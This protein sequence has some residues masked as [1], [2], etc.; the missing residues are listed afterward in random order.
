MSEPDFWKAT[1]TAK[2]CDAAQAALFAVS[3]HMKK[4]LGR[5]DWNE[6][7]GLRVKLGGIE[8]RMRFTWDMEREQRLEAELAAPPEAE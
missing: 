8:H 5:E 6:A 3:Q 2:L 4:V 1:E 7:Y